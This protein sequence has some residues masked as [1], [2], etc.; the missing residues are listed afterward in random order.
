L[1]LSPLAEECERRFSFT[2]AGKV[3]ANPK[4]HKAATTTIQRLGLNSRGL[5]SLRRSAIK[6]FFG[7]GDNRQPITI[8][9][10]RALQTELTKRRPPQQLRPFCFVFQQLL[11]KYIAGGM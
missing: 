1:F 5:V 9:A 7:F 6:G 4:G 2:W 8:P 10:A 3:R 11:P